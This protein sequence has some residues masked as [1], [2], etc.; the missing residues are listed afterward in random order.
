MR[1]TKLTVRFAAIPAVQLRS[2]Q[3]GAFGQF[4]KTGVSGMAGP[5]AQQALLVVAT[6]M[7]KSTKQVLEDR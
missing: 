1:P 7:K 5:K 6:A 3:W 2:I 4:P